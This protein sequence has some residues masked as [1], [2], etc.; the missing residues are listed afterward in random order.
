MGELNQHDLSQFNCNVFIETGTGKAVGTSYAVTFPQFKSLYTIE[1][2]PLLH[3]Y[4]KS[5]LKDPR[6]ELHCGNSIELLARIVPALSK[7]DRVLFWL[8]AHFPG[9]DYQLAPYRYEKEDMPLS[10][11]LQAICGSRDTRND[12]FIIDD[13]RLYENGP[14]E[15]GNATVPYDKPGIGFIERV[16]GKSHAVKRDYRHQG[17]LILTPN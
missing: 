16:L 12:S 9:A 6:L 7:E 5:K 14:F 13:L 15:L 3:E 4:A 17:F 10:M 1:V 2:I 8:D 11:E